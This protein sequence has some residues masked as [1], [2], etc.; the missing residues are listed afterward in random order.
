M[1]FSVTLLETRSI[2]QNR[3]DSTERRQ[4]KWAACYK[5]QDL[6]G[7][8]NLAGLCGYMNL[9]KTEMVQ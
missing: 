7:F 6:R 2:K 5:F 3:N 8:R 1:K 4:T 9:L